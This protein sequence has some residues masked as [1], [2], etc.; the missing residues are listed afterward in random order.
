MHHFNLHDVF[1]FPRWEHRKDQ[2]YEIACE[3][4]R[5]GLVGRGFE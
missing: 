1:R 4:V 5:R 3:S 2:L